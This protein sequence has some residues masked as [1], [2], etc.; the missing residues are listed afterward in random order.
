M[1]Q[2]FPHQQLKRT[3]IH[4]AKTNLAISYRSISSKE[5]LRA[6]ENWARGIQIR[7]FCSI[8]S[9]PGCSGY[10][11]ASHGRAGLKLYSSNSVFLMT[12]S[13]V[14]THTAGFGLFSFPDLTQTIT[15]QAESKMR[16]LNTAFPHS[17]GTGTPKGVTGHRWKCHLHRAA[18][19]PGELPGAGDTKATQ[20]TASCASCS[21]HT[22]PGVFPA[23][24]HNHLN[25][26]KSSR[27]VATP[28]NPS[29]F[30]QHHLRSR[31]EFPFSFINT[32]WTRSNRFCW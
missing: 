12:G 17:T 5:H 8:S 22:V 13:F 30:H 3:N 10:S 23:S 4:R 2:E 18:L 20:D 11:S 26:L 31:S 1:V 25:L 14:H 28:T 15:H 9:V 16:M 7:R 19:C 32:V 27:M 6:S 21:V 24:F 29:K